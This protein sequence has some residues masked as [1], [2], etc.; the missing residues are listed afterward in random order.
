MSSDCQSSNL[1]LLKDTLSSVNCKTKPSSIWSAMLSLISGASP[2]CNAKNFAESFWKPMACTL[3]ERSVSYNNKQIFTFQQ[4][5]IHIFCHKA[6]LTRL[7]LPNNVTWDL[8]NK[9]MGIHFFEHHFTQRPNQLSSLHWHH[10][11]VS[12][13]A[14]RRDDVI[15]QISALFSKFL[16]HLP[17]TH[18]IVTWTHTKIRVQ[19]QLSVNAI[20]AQIIVR[21]TWHC[22]S[23]VDMSY[24]V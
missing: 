19:L 21:T 12:V 5:M 3:H 22:A 9:L 15:Y 24:F 8:D 16:W 20:N 13:D 1:D 18:A 17:F 4:M 6:V 11:T 7:L 14:S 10:S 23:A 2:R